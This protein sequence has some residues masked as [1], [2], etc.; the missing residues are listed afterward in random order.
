MTGLSP[1]PAPARA[2]PRRYVD[3]RQDGWAKDCDAVLFTGVLRNPTPCGPWHC[4]VQV[5]VTNHANCNRGCLAVRNRIDRLARYPCFVRQG[6]TYSDINCTLY[7]TIIGV[8]NSKISIARPRELDCIATNVSWLLSFA[9]ADKR[10]NNSSQHRHCSKYVHRSPP[11]FRLLPSFQHFN[12]ITNRPKP[13]GRFRDHGRESNGLRVRR[14]AD[15]AM[16]AKSSVDFGGH[17]QRRSS[18]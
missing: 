4:S 2:K 6:Y 1:E 5:N 7:A 18:A 15:L 16:P 12:N 11:L 14:P 17:C 10:K 9:V 8:N 13:L 3:V